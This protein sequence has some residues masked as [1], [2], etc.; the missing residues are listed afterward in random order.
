MDDG[1]GSVASCVRFS[2]A[3]RC[4]VLSV[5]AGVPITQMQTLQQVY[6][7]SMSRTAF[8]LTLLAVS[9]GS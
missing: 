3:T 5:S 6:E 9:G 4:N 2:A 1:A 8:T 7:K